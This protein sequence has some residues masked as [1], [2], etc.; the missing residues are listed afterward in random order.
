MQFKTQQTTGLE[1]K[2]Q[3]DIHPNNGALLVVTALPSKGGTRQKLAARLVSNRAP[4]ISLPLRL[5]KL[6]ET[7]DS[8]AMTM[9]SLSLSVCFFTSY[10]CPNSESDLYL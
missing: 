4:L 8:H 10:V 7:P 1:N 3:R 5:Y 9:R 2:P 6:I